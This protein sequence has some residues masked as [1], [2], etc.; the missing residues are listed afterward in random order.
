MADI[1]LSVQIDVAPAEVYPLISSGPGLSK[2][3]AEDMTQQPGGVIDLGFFKRALVYSVRLVK[4]AAPSH[5][6][7]ACLT[8]K[9]WQGTKLLFDLVE[10]ISN[11]QTRQ[12]A[13]RVTLLTE[14]P[15]VLAGYYD[16]QSFGKGENARSSFADCWD[17]QGS[18]AALSIW[19]S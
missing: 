3:W 18:V 2:W 13:S 4:T 12:I 8:G 19:Q 11:L 1:R 9:E 10:P 14:V 17:F 5:T 6:E 16:V 15:D 7:W